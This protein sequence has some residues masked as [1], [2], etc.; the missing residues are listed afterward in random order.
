MHYLQSSNT[1]L[2][3]LTKP[4]L[5]ASCYFTQRTKHKRIRTELTHLRN[6]RAT[7]TAFRAQQ[8]NKDT[9]VHL[10]ISI[11]KT[12]INSNNRGKDHRSRKREEVKR[13]KSIQIR[14][15]ISKETK[16][17]MAR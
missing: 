4:E 5:A 9:I 10:D 13:T 14:E 7:D 6:P 12:I 11:K 2:S 1:K 3:K 15:E 16:R 17:L 8:S